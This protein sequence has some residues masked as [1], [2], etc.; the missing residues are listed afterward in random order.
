[1]DPVDSRLELNWLKNNHLYNKQ[2]CKFEIDYEDP[3]SVTFSGLRKPSGVNVLEVKV[4]FENHIMC[5]SRIN[6]QDV[7]F[8]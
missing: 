6:L 1:M 2:M 7:I 8:G 5:F 4:F 3:G